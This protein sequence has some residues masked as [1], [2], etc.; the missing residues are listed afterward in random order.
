MLNTFVLISYKTFILSSLIP[1]STCPLSPFCLNCNFQGQKL[2][3]KVCELTQTCNVNELHRSSTCCPRA[4]PVSGASRQC[5]CPGHPLAADS[6]GQWTWAVLAHQATAVMSIYDLNECPCF[7][8]AGLPP[9]LHSLNRL[10]AREAFVRMSLIMA[11]LH[12]VENNAFLVIFFK[13]NWILTPCSI[14]KSWDQQ[15]EDEIWHI[16]LLSQ[17][18]FI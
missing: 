12:C 5:R 11:I 8:C 7:S 16:L 18:S 9:S 10:R 1:F 3:W 17:K 15:K 4:Q 2:L 6:P 14:W 13:W